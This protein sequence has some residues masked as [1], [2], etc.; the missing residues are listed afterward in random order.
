[1]NSTGPLARGHLMWHST[2]S[3]WPL[4]FKQVYGQIRYLLWFSW[5]DDDLFFQTGV[6][7]G[8]NCLPSH[9]GTRCETYI[10]C[11]SSPC[12]NGGTCINEGNDYRCEFRTSGHNR[13]SYCVPFDKTLSGTK[14]NTI[15]CSFTCVVM[16]IIYYQKTFLMNA[17]NVKKVWDQNTFV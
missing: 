17:C 10:P 5:R 13:I 7:F 15:T 4:K 14:K 6:G 1:M 12:V 16:F 9:T 2:C 3:D 8:C 11:F